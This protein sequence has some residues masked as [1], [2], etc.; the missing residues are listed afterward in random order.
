V[1]TYEQTTGKL[2]YAGM[3]WG[4]GYA[5]FGEGKNNSALQSIPDVGPLPQGRYTIGQPYDSPR[6]GPF[7]LPLLPISHAAEFGRGDFR[8][9][10]DSAEHPG[11]ASHGCIVLPREVR[12]RIDRE[13][14]DR[15]IE[16]IA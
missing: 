13:N 6:T 10:G 4:V 3:T 1:L 2:T 9:H 14:T 12:E 7:T 8:I 5:G 11:A 15:L 16:V